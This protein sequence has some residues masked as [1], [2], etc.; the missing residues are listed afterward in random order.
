MLAISLS[1]DANLLKTYAE[2][3]SDEA[4]SLL[5]DRHGPWVFATA[6]RQLG[7]AHL[8]Q[9]ATQVV[10]ILLARR[11]CKMKGDPR[12]LPGWLFNTLHYTVKNMRRAR[13]RR[14][15]HEQAAAA[16]R[17][18]ATELPR[19]RLDQN[20]LQLDRAVGRLSR[21]DRTV[22]L[23]RFYQNCSFEQ[24]GGILEIS[25]D[26]ARKRVNR[27]VNTLRKYLG[28]N[29]DSAE[30]SAGAAVGAAAIPLHLTK[31]VTT[32]AL[33][34]KAGAALPAGIA[35]ATK[36]TV[37]LMT[38]AKL[39]IAAAI[40]G[41]VI[42]TVAVSAAVVQITAA[43]APAAPTGAVQAAAASTQ[44]AADGKPAPSD[45][46]TKIAAFHKVYS[47][48]KDEILKRIPPPF[49]AEREYGLM[50]LRQAQQAAM[51]ARAAATNPA[52]GP[53]GN[54]TP[55]RGLA[56]RGLG[57]GRGNRPFRVIITSV[58]PAEVV[59]QLDDG[60]LQLTDSLFGAL[61]M[62]ASDSKTV[63]SLGFLLF[64]NRRMNVDPSRLVEGD[65][66][67]LD[68]PIPGDF[69]VRDGAAPAE[70]A[71]ALQAEISQVLGKKVKA[72]YRLVD[73]KSYLLRGP[74]NF[75]PLTPDDIAGGVETVHIY[76]TDADLKNVIE[77]KPDGITGDI[78]ML[79]NDSLNM[80][81]G[82]GDRT[83]DVMHHIHCIMHIAPDQKVD[84]KAVLDHITEQTG[85]TWREGSQK[86]PHL[87]VEWA[88]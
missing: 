30:I 33:A 87:V 75:K 17:Q 27:A 83:A 54:P 65:K 35:A 46:D 16:S 62:S 39:Q 78:Q 52:N 66:D 77:D 8:A 5:V 4:F 64:Y 36:G 38:I 60:S 67:L 74:W 29:A 23:L 34:A 12:Q 51:A 41:A 49:I 48:Q 81:I 26:T 71:A 7:D 68:Q 85:L 45:W 70:L 73:E 11:A 88:K 18:T 14:I 6:Y 32:A 59:R 28:A 13:Q 69:V 72:D 1:D 3:R 19:E 10:F 55:G 57:A 86:T 42:A 80:H 22:I 20:A 24:V 84:P 21:A 15:R 9:D 76:A 40:G 2:S 53:A 56:G 61:G 50:D 47:L 82:W 63:R 58:S 79:L 37:W 43:G 25:E 31:H 44:P